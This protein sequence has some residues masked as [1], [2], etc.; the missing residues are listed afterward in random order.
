MTVLPARQRHF[1]VAY[2]LFFALLTFAAVITEIATTVERG[3]F[4]PGNFFSY[5]T[6]LSNLFATAVF[7]LTA[8]APSHGR[9]L[10]MLRGASTL[11]MVIVGITFS[12]LLAGIEDAEFTAAPWDN[13]VLHYVMPVAVV[14]DWFLDLPRI[15]IAF[16]SG[17]V[18]LVFPLGYVAYSLI[19][20]PVVDW[21]PYPFLDPD[22][23]GYGGI[24]IAV[25]GLAAVAVALT[26]LLTRFTGRDRAA[27]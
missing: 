9:K 15:R 17:L 3:T 12:L 26:W 23:N 24:A 20:G 22:E 1:L 27:V 10:A 8:L 5:F 13:I 18:W 16:T 6:I 2:R 11:Y 7:L 4:T 14:L 25:V 19:R 21:Y